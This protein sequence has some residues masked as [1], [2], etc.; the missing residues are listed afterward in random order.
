MN[1]RPNISP[2]VVPP[3]ARTPLYHWHERNGARIGERDGWQV[4]E[5]FAGV[6]QEVAAARKNLAIADVS[7]FAKISLLGAGV[8]D[9]TRTLAGNSR[10]EQPLGVAPLP[11]DPSLLACRLKQDHLLVMALTTDRSGVD[12]LIGPGPGE[13]V[14]QHD[15]TSA[16]AA[17]WLIG[18]NCDMALRQMTHHDVASMPVG[19]CAETGLAAVPAILIRPPKLSLPSV[20]VLVPWDVAEYVWETFVVSG[21]KR[22]I[23]PLGME[24]LDELLQ[25][26]GK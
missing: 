25:E 16:Y 22:N 1:S 4:A 24:A 3:L 21:R 19:S 9:L 13:S 6:E 2:S 17:I 23:A 20:Q 10:A 26:E 7:A 15:V 14:I 8:P 5:V 11:A 18:P 12:G